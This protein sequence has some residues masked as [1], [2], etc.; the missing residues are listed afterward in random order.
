MVVLSHFVSGSAT[1]ISIPEALGLVITGPPGSGKTS[2]AFQYALSVAAAGG[3]V[4]MFVA[5]GQDQGRVPKPQQSME[6]L[7][8][9]VLGRIEIIYV[10]T[11]QEICAALATI[12]TPLS[13]A[14]SPPSCIVVED[15][16]LHPSNDP[17]A[18]AALLASLGHTIQFLRHSFTARNAVFVIAFSGSTIP[19]AA[20]ASF[21]FA[22]IR[23]LVHALLEPGRTPS[24]DSVLFLTP[25]CGGIPDLERSYAMKFIWEVDRSVVTQPLVPLMSSLENS[26]AA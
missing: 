20:M 25:T 11:F 22:A 6:S 24:D 7:G 10:D 21:P 9:G 3:A 15:A 16:R 19:P 14:Q 17:R 12:G 13:C 23:S 4:I 1:T 5:S 2:F 8:E 18:A 26:L